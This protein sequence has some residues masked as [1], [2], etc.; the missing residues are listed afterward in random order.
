VGFPVAYK[1]HGLEA[2]P[3]VAI[4][5]LA[6]NAT[7]AVQGTSPPGGPQAAWPLCEEPPKVQDL[8]GSQQGQSPSTP[9][10]AKGAPEDAL[11][12]LEK[13]V[14]AEYLPPALEDLV[15]KAHVPFPFD[16]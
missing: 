5:R 3:C 13:L 16:R 9:K 12:K 15:M 10:K 6:P 1:V 14:R 4:E 7:W 11:Q 2:F 8:P